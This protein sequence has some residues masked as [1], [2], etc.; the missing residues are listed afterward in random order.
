MVCLNRLSISAILLL[1]L[2]EL[3]AAAPIAIR[4]ASVSESTE[5]TTRDL[6]NPIVESRD[7]KLKTVNAVSSVIKPM[8]KNPKRGLD[9]LEER[10]FE[11]LEEL[12]LVLRDAYADEINIDTRAPLA[13]TK[14]IK[15]VVTGTGKDL[16]KFAKV[17]NNNVRKKQ[18]ANKQAKRDYQDIQLVLRDAY[19]DEIDIDTR[20]PLAITKLIKNVVTGTGKDLDKFAKVHNNN[21]KKKQAA[22]KRL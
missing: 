6:K 2:G 4:E 10:D 22:N 21:V 8:N 20:A 3:A 5:I 18:T 1:N 11:I 12:G 17:H 16:D 14:L 7:E 9:D 13:I 15:N 19:A